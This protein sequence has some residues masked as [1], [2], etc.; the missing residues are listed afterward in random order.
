MET[1]LTNNANTAFKARLIAKARVKANNQL[2]DL[3]ALNS[4]DVNFAKKLSST[5]DLKKQYPNLSNYEDFD[6]WTNIIK[7]GLLKVGSSDVV[8]A[9]YNKKPCGIMSFHKNDNQIILSNLAKWRAMPN[10]DVSHV[11]KI[12]MHHLFDCGHKNNSLN[13]S[14]YSSFATPRGK[15]CKDFYSK[16]GFRRSINN[17][18]NLLG[19]DYSA[20]AKELEKYFDYKK[21]KNAPNINLEETFSSIV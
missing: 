5:I 19:V 2:I 4:S 11:G 21:I 15:S 16:L 6:A 7:N 8:L 9:C 20:K 13:I 1:R 18:M 12:L 3:Y 17:S 10:E 14:L